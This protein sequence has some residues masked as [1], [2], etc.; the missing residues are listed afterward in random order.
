MNW[1]KVV[2]TEKDSEYRMATEPALIL[3]TLKRL[4]TIVYTTPTGLVYGD[5]IA[6]ALAIYHRGFTASITTNSITVQG[7][8]YK[9]TLERL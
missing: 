3:D 8:F 2:D 4:R 6:R 5:A 7:E 1:T 9:A